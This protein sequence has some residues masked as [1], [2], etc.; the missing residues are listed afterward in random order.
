[1]AVGYLPKAVTKDKLFKIARERYIYWTD[2]YVDDSISAENMYENMSVSRFSGC[3]TDDFP[4]E[5]ANELIRYQYKD[6]G[7]SFMVD[8]IEVEVLDLRNLRK[9]KR[10]DYE[11]YTDTCVLSITYKDEPSGG[12]LFHIIPDALLYGST[13]EDFDE[14]NEVDPI[15]IAAARKYIKEHNI[16]PDMQKYNIIPAD[17]QKYLE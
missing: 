6:G 8:D 10:V 16:T 7:C 5:C 15:F 1:M 17:T 14:G 12:L 9:S 4:D 2:M 11:L 3:P 13:T